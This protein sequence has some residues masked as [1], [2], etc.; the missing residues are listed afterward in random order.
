ME[1]AGSDVVDEGP[2]KRLQGGGQPA[3]RVLVP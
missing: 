2:K 1:R 3:G